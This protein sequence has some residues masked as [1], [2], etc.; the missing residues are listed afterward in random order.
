MYKDNYIIG[1]QDDLKFLVSVKYNLF[2]PFNSGIYA[3]YSE[4]AWWDIYKES[5]PFREFNHNPEVFWRVDEGNNLFG[6]SLLS[7]VDYIQ[8]A[9]YEHKSNGRDGEV[10]RGL[11]RYY[12]Q[13]QG[14]IGDVINAGFN[15]KIWNYYHLAEENKDL[16]TYNGYGEGELFVKIK[17]GTV[18]YL[19]KEKLYIK[20]GIG[21]DPEKYWYEVGLMVRIITTHIQPRFYIQ[22]YNGYGEEL[23]NYNKKDQQVRAGFIFD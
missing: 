9:P 3:A 8:I 21:T 15:L 23:V 14:S 22:Y 17:S 4:T 11:D 12:A 13:I 1:S 7:Y 18:Q 19:D 16:K 2:Y 10:S 6:D 5:S 20:G